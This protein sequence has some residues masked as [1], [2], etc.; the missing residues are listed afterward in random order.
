MRPIFEVPGPC[1]CVCE[2]GIRSL[3]RSITGDPATF[4]SGR[5]VVL[6]SAR[7]SGNMKSFLDGR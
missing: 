6:D 2:G 4:P 3:T 1:V 5:G 7:K